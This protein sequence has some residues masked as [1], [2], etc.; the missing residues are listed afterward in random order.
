M[1]YSDLRDASW[2]RGAQTDS[3]LDTPFTRPEFAEWLGEDG[4]D[5]KLTEQQVE[6]CWQNYKSGVCWNGGTMPTSPDDTV[7]VYMVSKRGGPTKRRVLWHVSRT[8][9]MKICGD[10]RT[11]GRNSMLIWSDRCIDDPETMRFVKDDGRF[12]QVL[13]DHN[14]TILKK[15]D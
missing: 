6:I 15:A 7:C 12:A 3:E 2:H 11:S 10:D 8:D 13:A 14:V 1:T 9:G 4:R 5:A